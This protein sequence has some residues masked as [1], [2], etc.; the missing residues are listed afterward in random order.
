MITNASMKPRKIQRLTLVRAVDEVER[1]RLQ[2]VD[3]QRGEHEQRAGHRVED[4]LDRR[5]EP[6]RAAPHADEHVERDQHRLEERVEEQQVLRDEDAD[7]RA[8]EEEHQPEV[9]AR[10]GRARPRSRSRSRA[11]IATTVRPT[12]QSENAVL[13]DVVR[14]VQVLDP[15]RLLRE[16]QPAAREV[17][18]RDLL[19]PDAD[20][21]ERD[22]HRERAGRVA[23]ERQHPDD[24]RGADRQPDE[25]RGERRDR[26]RTSRKTIAST[27]MPVPRKKT[28]VRRRPVWSR[29]VRRPVSSVALAELA[30]DRQDPVVLDVRCR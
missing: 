20:L 18:A 16:L 30:A 2:P 7:G 8:G 14:D 28:Y 22:E 15:R 25:E 29:R 12:S 26:H 17:E 23:R 10:R 6:A 19:D 3:D 11:A 1:A 24:D 4:E 9:R 27:A 21:G 5:A 13:A